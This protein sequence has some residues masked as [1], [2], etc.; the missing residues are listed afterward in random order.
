M[1]E[2]ERFGTRIRRVSFSGTRAYEELRAIKGR[3]DVEVEMHAH[4]I[5]GW[6]WQTL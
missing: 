5:T 6:L 3:F 1:R 4:T 2:S